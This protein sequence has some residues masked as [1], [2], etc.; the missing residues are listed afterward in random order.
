MFNR[1]D[2]RAH[3]ALRAA[4][5]LFGCLILAQFG[6][7]AR[8]ADDFLDPAVA[9]KF[10]AAEKPGEVDVT[11]KIA[12]GYYMYRERFAFATR[13]GSAT[14][15]EPQLP[16]GHV[17]FDQTF[18]KNVETYR[19]E[20]TIRIPVKQA[21]VAFDLAVT[22]QGCADAGICY[23]PM[24][25]V[26]HVSGAALQ[27]AGSAAVPPPAAGNTPWY[28]RATSADY[29]QSLLQGGGFLAIIGLYFVAGVVLSLLP[30]SYPMIPILS[31]III[32]EGAGVTRAR[33]FALSL[34]YVIGMALVYTALGIAAALVGQSLGA[35]LQSAWV[36][37]VFGALLTIFALTLIAG[38][39]IALPQRWQDGVSHASAG[40]SG[41]KFAAVAAM[42]ALSALVV[43]AC[44]TAPLFAVLAFIAHTGNA[45]L[46]GA[47]LFAMG[48][49]LGVPLLIIGLG[50]GTLLPRA[51]AWMDGVKMLFGVVLLAAALWI[52]WPVLGA[53]ATMLLCALW[54]LIAAASLG[55][56][57]AATAEA[58]VWRR[59]GRG[60][61]A[62][63]AVWAAVLLVGLAAGSSDPL[64][65]LAVLASRSGPSAA[66]TAS[67]GAQAASQGDL[68]FQP[69]RSSVELDKAVKAVARP[70]MLD[71]YADW[72]VSCKEMEKFTFSDPRVQAKLK[73]MNLLRA[74]VTA[75]NADDQAL[76]KRFGLFG[77]P[78]IIFFDH[79]GKEVLRV[80]GYESADKFL[81]T[82]ER[83]SAPG[84]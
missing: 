17:K 27:A 62:A 21:E 54:L 52:V 23:P 63:L 72:C 84:A 24:E 57:S 8:A 22:S 7:L 81:R 6:T 46:G 64:R 33:G 4:F 82:L 30:C 1:L 2:R 53:T 35:W 16:S 32:G 10:S 67:S 74:D 37:G 9:F 13:N 58:S 80:V 26:Y 50:A 73:Q 71:F 3:H 29:A 76:L 55:L 48:L 14:V 68:A 5:L 38:F 42:G 43:G 56:F 77:P 70:A 45:V 69:V 49:G 15:G 41:G 75:N 25:R 59:L 36:L 61:G 20:L 51:G 47:A 28:E 12:D 44:M 11:Y 65:P 66:E 31:A 83:T 79:G 34:A 19:N 60:I 40:R 39:D 18:N 78:G